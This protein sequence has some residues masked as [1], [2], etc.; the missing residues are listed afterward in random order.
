[1]SSEKEIARLAAITRAQ[2]LWQTGGTVSRP[3]LINKSLTVMYVQPTDVLPGDGF[4][5]LLPCGET[6]THDYLAY[7]VTLPCDIILHAGPLE[8]KD[9]RYYYS[10]GKKRTRLT[11][12][13]SVTGEVDTMDFMNDEGFIIVVV[14]LQ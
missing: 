5:E 2:N 8:H 3:T 7:A 4:L 14:R 1:M 9:E 13:V 12:L 10:D 11:Y 6:P